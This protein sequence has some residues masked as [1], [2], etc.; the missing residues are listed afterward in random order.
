MTKIVIDKNPVTVRWHRLI[1]ISAEAYRKLL[2]C[3]IGIPPINS[4]LL[5]SSYRHNWWQWQLRISVGRDMTDRWIRREFDGHAHVIRDAREH[6]WCLKMYTSINFW[7]SY[8]ATSQTIYEHTYNIGQK[9]EIT[10]K[11]VHQ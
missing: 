10:D 8:K 2:T 1:D 11:N 9:Y 7:K 4:K 3:V 6:H 5:P